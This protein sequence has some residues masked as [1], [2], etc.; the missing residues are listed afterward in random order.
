M[1]A[2][3]AGFIGGACLQSALAQMPCSAGA[4]DI[5]A[6]GDRRVEQAGG[7]AMLVRAR[8]ARN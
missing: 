7:V 5:A 1:T 6:E 8:T 4:A 2:R 3:F